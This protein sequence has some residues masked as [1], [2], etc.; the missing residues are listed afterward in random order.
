[1]PPSERVSILFLSKSPLPMFDVSWMIPKPEIHFLDFPD[2]NPEEDPIKPIEFPRLELAAIKTKISDGPI[3]VHI[4]DWRFGKLLLAS[5]L[6]TQFDRQRLFVAVR[7][8]YDWE[9]HRD[10]S[11][12]A[13]LEKLPNLARAVIELPCEGLMKEFPEGTNFRGAFEIVRQRDAHVLEDLVIV[14]QSPFRNQINEAL[15]GRFRWIGTPRSQM[16]AWSHLIDL[17]SRLLEEPGDP[18]PAVIVL[19]HPVYQDEITLRELR[20]LGWPQIQ[21][22]HLSPPGYRGQSTSAFIRQPRFVE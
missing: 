2:P 10:A 16:P 17:C 12:L 8:P 3:L 18:I 7:I 22:I 20:R 4:T 9:G 19:R 14:L 15:K 21:L 6:L 5:E 11:N 13:A 1:M